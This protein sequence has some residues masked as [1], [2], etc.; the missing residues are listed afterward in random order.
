MNIKNILLWEVKILIFV[1]IMLMYLACLLFI[2]STWIVNRRD[3]INLWRTLLS[4]KK[5]TW[6]IFGANILSVIYIKLKIFLRLNS[7]SNLKLID[8][9]FHSMS[10]FTKFLKLTFWLSL[11]IVHEQPWN[12]C[13]LVDNFIHNHQFYSN[14]FHAKNLQYG[15]HIL[16]LRHPCLY[17]PEYTF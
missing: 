15:V 9:Q 17:W 2:I 12:I 14:I 16:T 5:L 4:K 13:N 1:Q 10:S 6:I 3:T 8:L 11:Q 7:T